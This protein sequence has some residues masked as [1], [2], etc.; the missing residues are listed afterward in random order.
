VIVHA[1]R[2]CAQAD[3]LCKELSADG[4]RAWRV[5]GDLQ[6]PGGPMP[7]SMPRSLRQAA[8]MRSSTTP[9]RSPRQPLT[10]ALPTDFER[11]WRLNTLA[12]VRLT[13]R[14]AAHLAERR[15]PGCVINLLDQRVA[16]PGTGDIPYLL[17]KKAL[18]AFTLSAALEFAPVPARQCRRARR[19]Y[20]PPAPAGQRACR[21][22]PLEERPTPEQIADAVRF[23][24]DAR[25]V[26]GQILYVDADSTSAR[27]SAGRSSFP[28]K[29]IRS[30]FMKSFPAFS[31]A[32][33]ALTLSGCAS[34]NKPPAVSS[35]PAP[36]AS[37]C[38]RAP[39]TKPASRPPSI[40]S[41]SAPS[42]KPARFFPRIPLRVSRLAD[43]DTLHPHLLFSKPDTLLPSA[44]K[45]ALN[46][47]TAGVEFTF[48]ST[49]VSATALTTITFT[50][51]T[52]FA[53]LLQAPGRRGD[54]HHR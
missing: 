8:W 18:E 34:F 27:V 24:L 39:K 54:R 52:R 29:I 46:L 11:L 43:L 14:L 51:Q 32:L 37:R 20:S 30:H 25:S 45:Q 40:P 13:Q 48:D 38:S 26:T 50:V 31:I 42:R 7:S 15:E 6:P 19:G 44:R 22:L 28:L 36:T 2:S 21:R 35:I 12:P 3:A 53:P 4:K 23:L 5:S 33:V 47:R 49:D 1:H 17:S 10:A 16:T 41:P 9:R